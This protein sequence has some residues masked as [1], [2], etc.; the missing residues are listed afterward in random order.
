MEMRSGEEKDVPAL[1]AIWRASVEATHEFLTPE[2]VDRL[3]PEV[4]EA[5]RALQVWVA[6]EDGVPV[7][8]MGMDGEVIEA[9]FID[10]RHRRKKLGARFIEHAQQTRGRDAAL[11]V[12]V[13]E[14]NPGAYAFYRA[15]GFVMVERSETDSAG[16]SWPILHLY[17]VRKTE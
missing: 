17:R 7:G 6:E 8:F 1:T 5:L 12:D 10:P 16:R 14:Q 9:L 11:R 4:R 15:M 3:E 2:D 13:N